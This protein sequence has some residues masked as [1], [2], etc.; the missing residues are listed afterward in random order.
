MCTL[1][2]QNF[3]FNFNF[4]RMMSPE[5]GRHDKSI[6]IE[7]QKMKFRDGHTDWR[8]F[9]FQ[10]LAQIPVFCIFPKVDSR[11]LL[12]FCYHVVATAKRRG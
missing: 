3:N 4:K 1:N 8:R 6:G 11:Y 5:A 10:V 12:S 9:V 2:G 7:Q